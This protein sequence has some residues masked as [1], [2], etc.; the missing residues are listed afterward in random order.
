[1][2]FLSVLP[3]FCQCYPVLS[4]LPCFCQYYPVYTRESII[5]TQISRNQ[6][7][8]CFSIMPEDSKTDNVPQEKK[9]DK[10]TGKLKARSVSL[11]RNDSRNQPSPKK[12]SPPSK[13]TS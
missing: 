8:I 9:E 11:T 1:M 13:K 7:R 12:T 5:S 4:V 2:G 6:Q 10:I 3:C